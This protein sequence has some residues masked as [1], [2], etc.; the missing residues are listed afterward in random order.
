[1]NERPQNREPGRK[2][3]GAGDRGER[4]R[5]VER[6]SEHEVRLHEREARCAHGGDRQGH[7]VEAVL[8]E[9]GTELTDVQRERSDV[10]ADQEQQGKDKGGEQ[11]D[12]LDSLEQSER[13]AAR[14]VEV[15]EP[16]LASRERQRD[17]GEQQREVEHR[18]CGK[19]QPDRIQPD[20][21]EDAHPPGHHEAVVRLAQSEALP[22]RHE[23][24]VSAS[25]A[26]R[27]RG[28]SRLPT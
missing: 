25:S 21:G 11:L 6:V 23:A 28:V 10:E 20:H 14:T 17:E 1:M 9:V 12:A 7:S 26:S 15:E 3:S 22:H 8:D 27:G 19:L 2:E 24:D 16:V 4:R 13:A 18:P 5:F